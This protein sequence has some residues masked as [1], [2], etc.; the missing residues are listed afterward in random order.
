MRRYKE[1]LLVANDFT[2]ENSCSIYQR[3]KNYLLGKIRDRFEVF[4]DVKFSKDEKSSGRDTIYH[5]VC[6]FKG[7]E[8]LD[9]RTLAAIRRR[10]AREKH[11]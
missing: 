3:K 10:Q 4:K 8:K 2:I 7:K 9:C 6:K 1:M 5:L 11:D